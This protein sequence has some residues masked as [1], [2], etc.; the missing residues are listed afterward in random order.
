MRLAVV[1]KIIG[2]H[3]ITFRELR[4]HL[5]VSDATLSKQCSILETAGLVS[6]T[7]TFVG[8]TPRTKLSLTAD[9]D[10]RWVEHRTALCELMGVDTGEFAEI[11]TASEPRGGCPQASAA[12]SD[13]DRAGT[14][15]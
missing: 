1:A 11:P 14:V 4:D 5:G 13:A 10:A 6:V 8:K 2:T 9:G 3:S 15:R 12:T 7:K